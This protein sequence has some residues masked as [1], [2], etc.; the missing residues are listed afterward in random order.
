MTY[1]VCSYCGSHEHTIDYCPKTYCGSSNR[2]HLRCSYCGGKDHNYE[3]C[4][5]HFGSGRI[6]GA[7]RIRRSV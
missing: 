7:V 5:K 1:V 4:T 2:L 6:K 3:A